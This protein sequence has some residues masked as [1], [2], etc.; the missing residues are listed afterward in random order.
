MA[1]ISGHDEALLRRME[2]SLR[3]GIVHRD[4]VPW[5]EHPAPPYFH[6]HWEQTYSPTA[7]RCPCG[8]YRGMGGWVRGRR[9]PRRVSGVFRSKH[10]RP[11]GA[12]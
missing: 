9:S 3:T 8:A 4:G 10:R 6:L 1:E 11:G 5:T 12:R 7:G 2:A